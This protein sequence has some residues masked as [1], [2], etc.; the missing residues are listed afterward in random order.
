MDALGCAAANG[1]ELTFD[2][3]KKGTLRPGKFADLAV[4]RADPLTVPETEITDIVSEMTWWAE[5]LSTKHRI[6]PTRQ[7]QRCGRSGCGEA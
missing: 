6:G 3:E 1:A 2:E 5:R 7:R 4:L